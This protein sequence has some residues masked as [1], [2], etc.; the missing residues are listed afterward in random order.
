LKEAFFVNDFENFR[1]AG[2][3]NA[4][5]THELRNVLAVIRETG[6]LLQDILAM[7]GA[8]PAH[9][10]TQRLTQGLGTI[11]DQVMR[12]SEILDRMNRFAHSADHPL[13]HFGI[14]EASLEFFQ[15]TERFLK[16]AQITLIPDTLEPDI[17]ME[18]SRFY[19]FTALFQAMEICL[20][21]PKDS[22]I[23]VSFSKDP[24][25]YFH[26]AHGF[27]ALSPRTLSG[28]FLLRGDTQGLW[29]GLSPEIVS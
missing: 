27:S 1:A 22:Q 4:S 20:D 23:R 12:G 8:D 10:K 21:L 19:F 18:A 7:A 15:L 11:R 14:R 29:V 5:L 26:G 6:G 28:G 2:R 25:L 9:P 17:P 3:I 13:E 16:L 24:G